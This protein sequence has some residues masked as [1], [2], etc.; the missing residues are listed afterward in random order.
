MR[1]ISIALLL[2]LAACTSGD[3]DEVCPARATCPPCGLDCVT[4]HGGDT[5][6]YCDLTQSPAVCALNP[7]S[8]DSAADC[9]PSQVCT[10]GVCADTYASCSVAADA[11]LSCPAAGEICETIGV[12][13]Q[14]LGCTFAKCSASG[15]CQTGVCFNGYCTGSVP[16]GGPCASSN[17]FQVCVT[18]MNLCSPAPAVSSCQRVCPSGQMLVLHDPDNIFDVCE[19]AYESCDCLDVPNF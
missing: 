8:C 4:A 18:A 9:C 16:C 3:S 2:A 15:A 14:G 7:R 11:G 19:I 6:W 17:G 12:R 10:N 13:P 5:R 1:R